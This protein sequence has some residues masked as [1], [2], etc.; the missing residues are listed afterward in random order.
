MHGGSSPD[1]TGHI[2]RGSGHLSLHSRDR[3]DEVFRMYP[4]N[5]NR[6]TYPMKPNNE[7]LLRRAHKC[8]RG[9][10][11]IFVTLSITV[12]FGLMSLVVD[13]GVMYK[14][15]RLLA[16][17]TQAAVLAGAEAM[18]LPGATLATTTT[19]VTAYSGMGGKQKDPDN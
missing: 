12:F 19:A 18:S 1:G 8:R 7:V 17:S 11:L 9:Q 15:Q 5:A 13:F 4:P 10:A 3:R 2:C 6:R 16:N 14:D